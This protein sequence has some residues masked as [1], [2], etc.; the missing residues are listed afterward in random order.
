MIPVIDCHD[1][2]IFELPTQ[3]L[4]KK[5]RVYAV[6]RMLM[7]F[8]AITHLVFCDSLFH[9]FAMRARIQT[10]LLQAFTQLRHDH[11]RISNQR[12]LGREVSSNR[13]TRDVDMNEIL[14]YRTTKA[15]GWDFAEARPNREQAVALRECI[16]R[17]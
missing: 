8:K 6:R 4:E 9:V 11:A 3:L 1:G 16:L 14:G 15:S 13:L 2:L 10:A 12:N 17:C 5:P 7:P